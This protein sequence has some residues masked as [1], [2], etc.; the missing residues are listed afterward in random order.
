MEWQAQGSFF[1]LLWYWIV[2]FCGFVWFWFLVF[3]EESFEKVCRSP[4]LWLYVIQK[5]QG[6]ESNKRD[7]NWQNKKINKNSDI[8]KGRSN[9]RIKESDKQYVP[10]LEKD[11]IKITDIIP[12]FYCFNFVVLFCSLLLLV[13]K[14]LPYWVHCTWIINMLQ[15]KHKYIFLATAVKI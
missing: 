13:L 10:A 6:N 14:K 3:A 5:S 15:Q 11:Q 7:L 2:F 8:W 9:E 4:R 12:N 1:K